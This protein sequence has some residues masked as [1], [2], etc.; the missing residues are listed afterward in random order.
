M[1]LG[2]VVYIE[3]LKNLPVAAILPEAFLEES[4]L[5]LETTL[6]VMVFALYAKLVNTCILFN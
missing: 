5:S 3:R 1:W 4:Q 6:V 2:T